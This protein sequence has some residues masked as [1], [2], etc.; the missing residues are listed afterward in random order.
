M[1]A[2]SSRQRKRGAAT[3]RSRP[4]TKRQRKNKVYMVNDCVEVDR[5]W[6]ECHFELPATAS[7][8]EVRARVTML[9]ST[10]MAH[11]DVCDEDDLNHF[12]RLRPNWPVLYDRWEA[13]RNHPDG[14]ERA[15]FVEAEGTSGITGTI[16]FVRGESSTVTEAVPLPNQYALGR[17]RTTEFDA[18]PLCVPP[19]DDED[20]NADVDDSDNAAESIPSPT[21]TAATA[22][23]VEVDDKPPSAAGKVSAALPVECDELSATPLPPVQGAVGSRTRRCESY[24]STLRL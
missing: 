6:I 20:Y 3:D 24:G 7:G 8:R 12:L 9:C 15:V 4:R 10:M 17:T 1:S 19:S 22:R 13:N 21:D 11:V 14:V 18:L 5:K 23:T 2:S 16:K